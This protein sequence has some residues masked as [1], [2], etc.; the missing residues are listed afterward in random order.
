MFG[1]FVSAW[2]GKGWDV[3][4]KRS[5]HILTLYGRVR[6]ENE[7][8]KGYDAEKQNGKKNDTETTRARR[9]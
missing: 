6:A 4:S 9:T 7:N 8:A 1:P 2:G 5:A 3:H